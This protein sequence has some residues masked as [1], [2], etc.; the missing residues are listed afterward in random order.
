MC[1]QFLVPPIGLA[2]QRRPDFK[3]LKVDIRDLAISFQKSRPST[4]NVTAYPTFDTRLILKK[5]D[6]PINYNF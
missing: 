6:W 1:P 2:S 3:K 5:P 4:L